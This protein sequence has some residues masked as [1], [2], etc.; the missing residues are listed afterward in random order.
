MNILVVLQEAII[1]SF[2]SIFG[3]ALI[4]FPLMM[5]LEIVKDLNILDRLSAIIRPVSRLFN[6]PQEAGLPLLAGLIFGITYGAG[7]I[8][9]SAREGKLTKRDLVV[10]N[11]FLVICHAVFEDTM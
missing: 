3:I 4:V 8:I 7:A 6:I 10:V 11:T 1:G 2:K 5:V 9:Q